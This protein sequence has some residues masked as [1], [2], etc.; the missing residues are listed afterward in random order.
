MAWNRK[1]HF[2]KEE[3]R[4]HVQIVARETLN[5]SRAPIVG[6]QKYPP[7]WWMT[8]QLRVFWEPQVPEATVNVIVDAVEKRI[9]E[10]GLDPFALVL[11]GS[12]P[13][14]MEQVESSLVHGRLDFEK[15]FTTALTEVWRDESRGGED[16]G[17]IYITTKP[18]HDEMASWGAADFKS[19]TM[20]FSLHSGRVDSRHHN[21]LRRIALHETT[22]LFGM[23]THCDEYQNVDELPYSEVC[24]MHW[25][26]SHSTL[27]PKCQ[28]LL[29]TWWVQ[30]E[31]ECNQLSNG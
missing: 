1:R 7:L 14:A 12:H 6:G 29:E 19:G 23:Y 9:E 20:I 3:F 25:V 22:H 10:I 15:L 13:S 2:T 26:C 31:Y 30:M 17:D 5:G 27:C 16:H 24:N 21:F 11:L 4:R 18:F 28:F 8:K